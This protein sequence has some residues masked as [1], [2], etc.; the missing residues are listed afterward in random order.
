MSRLRVVFEHMHAEP[1][2]P[3]EIS[4][5]MSLGYGDTRTVLPFSVCDTGFIRLRAHNLGIRLD[6]DKLVQRIG[7]FARGVISVAVIETLPHHGIILVEDNKHPAIEFEL[8]DNSKCD[9]DIL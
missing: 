8:E 9:Y 3:I 1:N 7:D 4:G 2:K 6:S 5:T